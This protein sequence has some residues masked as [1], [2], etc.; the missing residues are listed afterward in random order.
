VVTG[1]VAV[2]LL[3]LA[4]C[5]TMRKV[6]EYTN[7][8]FGNDPVTQAVTSSAVSRA[9]G[10]CYADCRPG[11]RCN[12]E[13][14]LCEPVPAAQGSLFLVSSDGGTAPGR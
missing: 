14:G 1:F 12:P 6:H 2:G 4:G 10:G 5:R 13:N 8:G 7:F 11:H 3:G 9:S